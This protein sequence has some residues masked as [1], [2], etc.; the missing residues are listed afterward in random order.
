[1]AFGIE[2]LV[3]RLS[4]D[5]SI[6]SPVPSVSA[7]LGNITKLVYL[8]LLQKGAERGTR[9]ESKNDEEQRTNIISNQGQGKE[10]SNQAITKTRRTI[11]TLPDTS[12]P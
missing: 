3:R 8:V 10:A 2:L 11:F 7:L 1:M 12:H 5:F 9:G 6:S 4:I